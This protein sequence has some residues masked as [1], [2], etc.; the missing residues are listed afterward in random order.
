M[1]QVIPFFVFLALVIV[2]LS[3]SFIPSCHYVDSGPI[4][5]K[6]YDDQQNLDISILCDAQVRAE[7]E[8][9]IREEIESLARTI[10]AEAPGLR[11]SSDFPNL[12]SKKLRQVIQEGLR[13]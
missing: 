8:T 7:A 6:R 1:E 4:D 13:T 11:F 3:F 2:F 12:D 5:R 9:R 10:G